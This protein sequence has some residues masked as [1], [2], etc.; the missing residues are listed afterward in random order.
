[1]PLHPP[2][3]NSTRDWVPMK[4]PSTSTDLVLK[5]KPEAWL[6]E[7]E[8]A[9]LDGRDDGK[10]LNPLENPPCPNPE[11]PCMWEDPC[12]TKDP[13]NDEPPPMYVGIGA[14]IAFKFGA[15]PL[16]GLSKG[17]K[18]SDIHIPFLLF[19]LFVDIFLFLVWIPSFFIV[20]GLATWKIQMIYIYYSSVWLWN[21]KC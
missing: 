18:R 7:K 19:L 4:T 15:N 9:K 8:E 3:L 16:N 17:F 10:L 21:K 11:D 20:K 12:G 13:P 14:C 1:M 5:G 2:Y 6:L